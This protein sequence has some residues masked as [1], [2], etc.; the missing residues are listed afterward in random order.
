MKRETIIKRAMQRV[1]TGK[2]RFSCV[3]LIEA[4]SSED[5]FASIGTALAYTYCFANSI[6]S[7]FWGFDADPEIAKA[8]RLTALALFLV[9]GEDL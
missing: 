9:A 6:H 1:A 5:E 3:A 7:P 8:E 4:E 2:E